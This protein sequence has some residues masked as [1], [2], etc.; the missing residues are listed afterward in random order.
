MDRAG[1]FRGTMRTSKTVEDLKDNRDEFV[2][3]GVSPVEQLYSIIDVLLN[4]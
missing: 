3:R 2:F 4:E 1:V